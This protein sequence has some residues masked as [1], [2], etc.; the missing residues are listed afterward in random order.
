MGIDENER[1]AGTIEDLQEGE[2]GEGEL[3]QTVSRAIENAQ[4]VDVAHVQ[5]GKLVIVGIEALK[6]GQAV[7][8]EFRDEGGRQ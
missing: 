4:G 5:T 2:T 6:L 7:E 3:C 8:G 1:I